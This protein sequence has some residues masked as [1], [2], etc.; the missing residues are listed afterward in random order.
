MGS[1][2]HD[3]VNI[4]QAFVCIIMQDVHAKELCV[5]KGLSGTKGSVVVQSLWV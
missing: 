1:Q 5:L 2:P 3:R 4:S